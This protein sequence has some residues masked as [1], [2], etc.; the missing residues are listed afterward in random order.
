MI[1]IYTKEQCIYCAM[2]KETLKLRGVP[3]IER[4]LHEDF[5]RDTVLEKFA[6]QTTFPF[7]VVDNSLIG[8][9]T[10]LLEYYKKETA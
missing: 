3:Y 4:K 5:D 9:Y 2:A 6:P 8:G 1:E 7:I 10:D